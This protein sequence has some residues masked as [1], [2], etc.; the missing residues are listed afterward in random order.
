MSLHSR[1]PAANPHVAC[2]VQVHV[3]FEC[4]K[5][6]DARVMVPRSFQSVSLPLEC[7]NS[8]FMS[9]SFDTVLFD[10]IIRSSTWL[11]QKN[12]CLR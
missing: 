2:T 1:K 6:L 7:K 10:D 12:V 8:V 5:N 9:E 3:T 11:Y 4:G